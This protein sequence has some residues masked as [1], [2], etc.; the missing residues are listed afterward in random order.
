MEAAKARRTFLTSSSS[1]SRRELGNGKDGVVLAW[2]LETATLPS[3]F[4]SS[5]Y[6]NRIALEA[7]ISTSRQAL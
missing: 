2:S 1:G 6:L 3:L 4:T 5:Q 7:L